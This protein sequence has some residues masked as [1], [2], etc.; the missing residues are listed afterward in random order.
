MDGLKWVD[1]TYVEKH[2]SE[3]PKT[4]RAMYYPNLTQY[5]SSLPPKSKSLKA[6]PWDGGV[7]FFNR[8]ARRAIVSLTFLLL[9]HVPYFGKFIL[10]VISFYTFDKKVG[11]KPAVIIFALGLFIPRK[12]F[13]VFLQTYFA[14]R[15][16]VTELVSCLSISITK[17]CLTDS[18]RTLL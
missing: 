4:L 13:V 14:S 12:Y 7:Q 11:N 18:A 15:S 9:S 10:P 17:S 16:M 2:H 1:Q 8:Y 6:S 3:D 5:K